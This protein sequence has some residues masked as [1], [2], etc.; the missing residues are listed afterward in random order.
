VRGDVAG[1]GFEGFTR[2]D[3]LLVVH[4]AAPDTIEVDGTRVP[5]VAGRVTLPNRGASFSMV[6]DL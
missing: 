5:V 4:G 6:L 1:E 3:F 2:E